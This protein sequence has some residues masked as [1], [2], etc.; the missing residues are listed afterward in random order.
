[1]TE[2]A[3]SIINYA[4]NQGIEL[5]NHF[6]D[7]LTVVID[8]RHRVHLEVMTQTS[9]ALRYRLA[10]LPPNGAARDGVLLKIGRLA[11]STLSHYQAACVV[12]RREFSI[13]LQQVVELDEGDSIEQSMCQFMDA[14]VLWVDELP[15]LT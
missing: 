11:A 7:L 4:V 12:D 10:D 13:W 8:D 9:V 6:S 3:S 1:M 5:P 14:L 15:R 2:A